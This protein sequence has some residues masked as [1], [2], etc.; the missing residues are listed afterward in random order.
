MCLGAAQT[1]YKCH[2]CA[3]S[4]DQ[5]LRLRRPFHGRDGIRKSKLSR[6]LSCP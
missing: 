1:W 3:R 4:Y 6:E 2:G 5:P